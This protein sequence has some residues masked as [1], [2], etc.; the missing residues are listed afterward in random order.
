MECYSPG[1]AFKNECN[2]TK[3]I[4]RQP[5]PHVAMNQPELTV[6]VKYTSDFED[7]V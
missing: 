5:E 2:Q 4:S 1:T 6:S 7:L 3:R